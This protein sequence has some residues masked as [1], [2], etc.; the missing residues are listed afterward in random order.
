MSALPTASYPKNLKAIPGQGDKNLSP[1][2]PGKSAPALNLLKNSVT[3][4][5]SDRLQKASRLPGRVDLTNK[6]WMS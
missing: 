3:K 5:G 2:A 4:A 6:H 1:F